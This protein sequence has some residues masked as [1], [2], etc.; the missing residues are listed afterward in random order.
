MGLRT[1]GRRAK[2]LKNRVKSSKIELRF[3]EVRSEGRPPGSSVQQALIRRDFTT[4]KAQKPR[5]IK[6]FRGFLISVAFV[7]LS[8]NLMGFDPVCPSRMNSTFFAGQMPPQN[9]CHELA[10]PARTPRI[11]LS[12]G[13]LFP[14]GNGIIWSTYLTRGNVAAKAPSG[15]RRIDEQGNGDKPRVDQHRVYQGICPSAKAGHWKRRF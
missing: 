11:S 7:Q 15:V 6:V 2:S 8:K 13:L 14:A 9:R 10:V 12:G 5:K 1:G 3:R 4:K